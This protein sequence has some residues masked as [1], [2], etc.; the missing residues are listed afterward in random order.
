MLNRLVESFRKRGARLTD[1]MRMTR[2][3]EPVPEAT[4]APEQKS[5]PAK[6]PSMP[7][8]RKPLAFVDTE[9]T[10]LDTLENEIIELAFILESQGGSDG[11]WPSDRW[12]WKLEA[13]AM[14]GEPHSHFVHNE[15]SLLEF[16]TRI[17]PQRIETAHPIALEVNGYTEEGWKHMP[18]FDATFAEVLVGVLR[19]VVFIAHNV[20]F[21][22]EFISRS[23]HRASIS[24]KFGYHKIDTVTLAFEHLRGATDSLSLD[25][26]C[27]ILGVTN[28]NAHTALADVQRCR[29]VYYKLLGATE[30]QRRTWGA[31]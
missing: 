12:V 28:E 14:L 24:P 5:K 25:H 4:T 8:A 7:L 31:Q 30:E 26:I 1:T 6:R 22:H 3:Q 10:G 20:S 16:A 17:K 13:L 18:R 29:E 11:W 19:N 15:G 27:P 21:D 2:G 9:T 23:C